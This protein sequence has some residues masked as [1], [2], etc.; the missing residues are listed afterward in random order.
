QVTKE[1]YGSP[2]P[3]PLNRVLPWMKQRA[4][5]KSLSS[6]GWADKTT[7]QVCEEIRTC[8]QALS[9]KLG[10]QAYFMGDLPTELDAL[11]YGHLFT[12]ITTHLPSLPLSQIVQ[13]FPNLNEYCRRIDEDYFHEMLPDS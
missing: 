11:V 13:S 7:D 9:E 6:I 3:W 10:D 4:V 5:R 1:R 8:C 2:F 12:L